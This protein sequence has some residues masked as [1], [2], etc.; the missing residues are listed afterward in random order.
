MDGDDEINFGKYLTIVSVMENKYGE[1]WREV[2]NVVDKDNDGYISKEDIR[3]FNRDRGREITDAKIEGT[4]AKMDLDG[5]GKISPEEF[6][7]F[8]MTYIKGK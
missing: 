4:I 5:D 6:R 7:I 2:F 1:R 3:T 8:G